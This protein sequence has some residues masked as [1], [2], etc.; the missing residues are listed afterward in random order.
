M[1]KRVRHPEW[2]NERGFTGVEFLIVI[3]LIGILL[4]VAVP[5]YLSFRDR[6]ASNE[7][8][9]NLR[10]ALPAASQY[11]AAHGT[12]KGME[13]TD[14]IAYDQ[15]LSTT[16]AVTSASVKH[17]CLTDTVSNKTW[18]VSGPSPSGA[19]FTNSEACP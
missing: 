12:Y 8:K 15:K 4:A 5:S 10:A 2:G 3:V 7:A 13:T 18:S 17:F 11:F 9:S 14:L 19:D 1:T 16:L 6:L